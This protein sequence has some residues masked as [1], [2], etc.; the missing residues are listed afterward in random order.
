MMLTDTFKLL[1]DPPQFETLL[2][3]GTNSF[4]VTLNKDFFYPIKRLSLA[5]RPAEFV[6]QSAIYLLRRACGGRSKF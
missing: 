5:G 6:R 1:S 2:D 3:E 4:N